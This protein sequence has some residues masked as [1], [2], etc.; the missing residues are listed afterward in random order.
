MG[1]LLH[2]LKGQ[3]ILISSELCRRCKP[4]HTHARESSLSLNFQVINTGRSV[5]LAHSQ[6]AHQEALA[7][8]SRAREIRGIKIVS[9]CSK[10]YCLLQHVKCHR[11]HFFLNFYVW[12]L[13]HFQTANF[14]FHHHRQSI[15]LLKNLEKSSIL[16]WR[17]LEFVGELP[18]YC[19]NVCTHTIIKMLKTISSYYFRWKICKQD[20]PE[21]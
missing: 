15:E 14:I 3:V 1:L 17:H 8:N 9:P 12:Q 7:I 16:I 20:L 19:I 10:Y 2:R 11:I 21:H 13:V 5:L 18:L 6:S 4:R